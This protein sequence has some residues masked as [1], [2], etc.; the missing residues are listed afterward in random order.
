MTSVSETLLAKLRNSDAGREVL[1]A[2]GKKGR[3]LVIVSGLTGSSRA[4]LAALVRADTGRPV[5]AMLPDERPAEDRKDDLEFFLP[6]DEVVFFPEK[7]TPPYKESRDFSSITDARLTAL[8]IL[9]RKS[10]GVLV[11]TV[12]AVME[13]VPS[14]KLFSSSAVTLK[15]GREIDLEDLARRLVTMGFTRQ[16]VVTQA[17]EMSVRG[18]ILDVFS[19]G[20]AGPWRVELDGDVVSSIR[21]FDADTQLSVSTEK[22]ARVLPLYELAVTDEVLAR[23]R[24]CPEGSEEREFLQRIDDGICLSTLVH[25]RGRL[26]QDLTS[27]TSYL[28]EDTV[29]ILE[30]ERKLFDKAV[31]FEREVTR[32]WEA[33]SRHEAPLSAPHELYLS[34]GELTGL[35]SSFARVSEPGVIEATAFVPGVP[36][37]VVGVDGG[38]GAEEPSDAGP[39]GPAQAPGAGQPPGRAA[40]RV[41]RI[42]LASREPESVGRDMKLLHRYLDELASSGMLTYVFCDTRA[43][44][45]RLE[46]LLA[47]DDVVVEPGRLSSGFIL[48]ELKLAVLTDTELFSRYRWRRFKR[49]LNLGLAIRDL[50]ALRPGDYVVHY[51]YGIGVYRGFKRLTVGGHETDC[52]EIGYAGGDKLYIP[53]DQLSLIQKYQ[54][55]EGHV[56]SIHRIG[57]TLWKRTKARARK[58]IVDMAKELIEVEARRKALYGHS[59]SPDTVWQKELESSFVYEETPDQ[60]QAC[61]D[62]KADMEAASPME[63]LVCGDVGYGKTEVAVRASFKSVMDAKQVAVLVPTTVLAQQ[64]LTTFT[65]RLAGY[66]VRVE[67]LSRFKTRQEQKAIVEGL[68]SGTVDI[69]IGTH[70]LLQKDVEFKDLGLLVIDEEQRFG[71]AHKQTLRKKKHLVDVLTMTATPIPRTLHMSLVGARDMSLVNTPPRDRIPIRTEIVEFNEELIREALMREAD[72]GGQSFF[73]HN[74]VETIKSMA[75]MLEEL[76]PELRFAVAHGQMRERE[77]EEVILR[78]IDREFDVLVCTMIIESGVDMP[79]VNTMIVNRAD[80]FGLAQLYQLRG[81]VGRAREQ[82]YAYLLVP[83]GKALTEAAERRLRAVEECDELGAGFKIA[84]RDLEIRGAGNMLGPEQ[85]GFMLSVGFDLYC[86]L[87]EE[88]VAE[89]K[90]Q[91]VETEKMPRLKAELDAYIPEEYVADDAERMSLYRKLAETR[92]PEAVSLVEKELED[93]FGPLPIPTL[94]LL[95]LRRIRLQCKSLPLDSITVGRDRSLLTLSRRLSKREATCLVRTLP[96]QIEFAMG[97]RM[98]IRLTNEAGTPFSRTKKLLKALNSCAS[99]K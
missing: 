17:G 81:R 63:R 51:E 95:E 47:R 86:R 16:P 21:I 76:A 74:R 10:P 52:L 44:Q 61:E 3:P 85:H 42:E 73:V 75:A 46:E 9:A 49:R 55:E 18:G 26:A 78:F 94:S 40:E 68:K 34:P 59:F 30:D 4:M 29:F 43:Q 91:P 64:H 13:R 45:A 54:S 41:R 36:S 97:Q 67:M 22:E 27:V 35:L 80:T 2:L 48:P 1:R 5:V 60:L 70:R 24:D 37:A 93:R 56:P 66:P 88:A 7:D 82:A 53:V 28:P 65:E 72:R 62:V 90:G 25:S 20:Q 8:D 19:F 84:M 39:P 12:R 98:Q 11:T 79:N 6:E 57:G 77:L 33:T 14:K 87:L 71:V 23:L 99:V 69:A 31:Y 83:P 92:A 89:L 15:T 32:A 58:A 96:F 38:V 50:S